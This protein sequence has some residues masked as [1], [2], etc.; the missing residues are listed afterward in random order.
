MQTYQGSCHC[1]AV[2][3][4]VDLELTEVIKCNCSI[5]IRKGLLLAFAPES[6]FTLKKGEGEL[7]EYRFNKKNIAH[8]FCKICGVQAFGKGALP[9]GTPTVA[10]NVCCLE[11]VDVALLEVKQMDG[12]SF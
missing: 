1:Q 10:V 3:F 4:E 11:G 9:D 2:L 6:A 5:C 7:T 8:L 12:K